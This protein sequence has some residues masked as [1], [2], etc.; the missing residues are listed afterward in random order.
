MAKEP[1][2]PNPFSGTTTDR[3]EIVIDFDPAQSAVVTTCA[4]IADIQFVRITADGTAM[5]PGTYYSGFDYRDPV[6][7]DAFWFV[8]FTQGE[9]RPDYQ[10]G[11]LIGQLGYKNGGTRNAWIPDAPVTSG[12][13]RRFYSVGNPDGWQTVVFEF[14]TFCWCMKGTQC[15]T[16]YE[17]MAWTYT[18]TWQNQR[19]G[20]P[21]RVAITT[22]EIAPPPGAELLAAFTLFNTTFNYVPCAG[23][24]FARMERV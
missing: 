16:W 14:R 19:D 13:D 3:N 2:M 24:T 20:D 11:G 15:N 23:A 22:A 4:E 12:G 9:Q 8:D 5:L 1:S 17:G 18:K 7:T 21:G 6:T 10:Q